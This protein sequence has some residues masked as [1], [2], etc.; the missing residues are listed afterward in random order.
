MR[1]EDR[2]FCSKIFRWYVQIPPFF[3]LSLLGPSL[4]Q[5][6]CPSVRWIIG[7][8]DIIV[9]GRPVQNRVQTTSKRVRKD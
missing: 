5:M 2:M 7:L 4:V 9:A 8:F 3:F 6:G 1:L